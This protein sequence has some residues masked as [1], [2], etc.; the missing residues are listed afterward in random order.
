MYLLIDLYPQNSFAWSGCILSIIFAWTFRKFTLLSRLQ[1][2]GIGHADQS[3]ST[4][5]DYKKALKLCHTEIQFLGVGG[6]KLTELPEFEEAV[7]RCSR[8]GTI[9]LLLSHPENRQIADAARLAGGNELDY[10]NKIITSLRKIKEIKERG[11][12]PIEV[13]FYPHTLLRDYQQFRLM[14]IDDRLCLMSY[15]V[16]GSGNGSD[17]PQLHLRNF[18]RGDSTGT[19]YYP[20]RNYFNR[21]WDES[22]VWNFVDHIA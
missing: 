4:G 20:M 11:R 13:R 8:H 10:K 6:S 14:F 21:L 9:Q 3:V 12:Y 2:V 22:T 1:A 5:T 18:D 16:W 15:A 17:L 7:K 19:F